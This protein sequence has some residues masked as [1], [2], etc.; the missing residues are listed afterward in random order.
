MR[1]GWL[2]I[3]QGLFLRVDVQNA[4]E[5]RFQY[6]AILTAQIW[7]HVANRTPFS[8]GTQWEIPS[9]RDNPMLLS[10]VANHVAVFGSTYP[11]AGKAI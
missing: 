8:C 3:S 1:S 6:P 10:R 7:S 5:E 2:V 9:G 4:Q 11:H